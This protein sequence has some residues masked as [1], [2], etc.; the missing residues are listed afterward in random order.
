M[1][2]NENCEEEAEPTCPN[3]AEPTSPNEAEPTCPD[4]AEQCNQEQRNENDAQVRRKDDDHFDK[5]NNFLD[6]ENILLDVR[7]RKSILHMFKFQHPTKIQKLA[8]PYVLKGSDVI[9]S[10][11]TGSGKTMAYLIP[12]VQNII[13]SNLNEKESLKFFYKGIILAPTEELCLQIYEI[14]HKLCSYL[15]D[16]LSVNHNIGKTFYEHPSVL[17]ST[18]RHLYNHIVECK[19]K[20]NLDILSNLKILVVDEADILHSKG[21]QKWMNLLARYHFPKNYS[22]KYQIIMASATIGNNIIGKTKLFLHEP[23]F[24][25]TE[26]EKKINPSPT[27]TIAS[28]T[29]VLGNGVNFNK[30]RDDKHISDHHDNCIKTNAPPMDTHSITRS[31]NTDDVVISPRTCESYNDKKFI[32]TSFYYLYPDEVTKFIYLYNLI[33]DKIILHKSIIFTSTIHDAYKIKIFL[34]YFDIPCSIL[35][36]NHPIL[37]RQNIISAFN[38]FKMFFLICPQYEKNTAGKMNKKRNLITDNSVPKSN[39]SSITEENLS[40]KDI[41]SCKT[42]RSETISFTKEEIRNIYAGDTE[43]GVQNPDTDSCK[44]G[45]HFSDTDSCKDGEQFSDT[46]SC[47][48]GEQFSDTDSCKD[49]E[50]NPDTDSCEDEEQ[51]SDT[52]SCEDGEQNSDGS[53]GEEKDFLYNRGLDFRDVQCVV[54]FD[55]PLNTKTF[56][57]RVGRTCR[58]NRKGISISFINQNEDR[59]KKMV[60]TISDKNICNMNKK[61]VSINKVEMYRY[62]VESVLNKCTKKKVKYFIQKEILYQSLK[63][64]E[65]KEYFNLN[66][67]E[68][69]HINKI[70]KY[71]NT[72][73][74]PHKLIK[75][76]L[77]NLFLK[78][79]KIGTNKMINKNVGKNG[80]QNYNKKKNWNYQQN[81]GN[82]NETYKSKILPQHYVKNKTN[83][84]MLTEMA[85]ENQLRK[86]PEIDV[87]DPS[88]LPPIYGKRLKSYI[89]KKYIL[90][91]RR[92]SGSWRSDHRTSYKNN[93]GGG[94]SEYT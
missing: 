39:H 80:A 26:M 77:Q 61:S 12:L 2:A 29:T 8:I 17:V 83:G 30:Q 7:L 54:N 64:K 84:F 51:N 53:S 50:Q 22:K 76:R 36:P 16:I 60:N 86:E 92:R 11:K 79:K 69:E 56:I 37:V 23:V 18:P 91:K 9:I 10:S 28:I 65:L 66:I 46:D 75:D 87:A 13:K 49:G 1:R 41:V 59:E 52:D 82:N 71:F 32:G 45:E 88:K 38:N 58:L 70:I 40:I 48:D 67:Q 72:H 21:F 24:L 35:N 78:R 43:D 42:N 34:T 44:D 6:F 5:S 90:R 47:K 81:N 25:T 74:V 89:Y 94:G 85:Y 33:N 20:N 73:V 55:M 93:Q 62:R 3:E 63:S 68:K 14:T 4:K 31:H 27:R 57:H 15:K 19:R